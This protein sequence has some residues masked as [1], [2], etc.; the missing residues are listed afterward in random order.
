MKKD[1]DIN[2]YNSEPSQHLH[3]L[4]IP[5]SIVRSIRELV[6]FILGITVYFSSDPSSIYLKYSG[7]AAILYLFLKVF[8]IYLKWYHFKYQFTKKGIYIYE[9]NITKKRRFIPLERIQNISSHTSLFH[10]LFR[11]T[12]IILETGGNEG[13]SSVKLM[14]SI[15]ELQR[16]HRNYLKVFTIDKTLLVNTKDNKSKLRESSTTEVHYEMD[17]KTVFKA[18]LTSLKLIFFIPVLYGLYNN[19]DGF[20]SVDILLEK[21]IFFFNQSIIMTLIGMFLLFALSLL[22]GFL[23]TYFQI[24]NFQVTSDE[25]TIFIKKG[26]LTQTEFSIT[27]EKIK[28]VSLD[29]TILKKAL[30]IVTVKVITTGEK[31]DNELRNA[32]VLFPIINKDK[33]FQLLST[34]VPEFKITPNMIRVPVYSIIPKLIRSSYIWI[35]ALIITF[36][37]YPEYWYAA[38]FLSVLVVISQVLNGVYNSYN[39]QDE[40]IQIQKGSFFTRFFIV[41]RMKIEELQV[42]ES[43]LQ[44]SL[45]LAS[46]Q[47]VLRARPYKKIKIQDLP[48]GVAEHSYYWFKDKDK[49][50]SYDSLIL[51]QKITR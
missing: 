41:S 23:K 50:E 22:Y 39:L 25:D 33:A 26:I 27:K 35:A 17:I 24:R 38:L 8:F 9:G 7:L 30:G 46:L 4:W 16:I 37:F 2:N 21:T 40:F 18:S 45:G 29:S 10:R 28:A 43:A 12:T 32:S 34:V 5:F 44:R 47:I 42:T 15:K 48:K 20:L 11:I 3:P 14:I 13:E 36:Y 51:R 49:N 1:D 31:E 19:I 6:F